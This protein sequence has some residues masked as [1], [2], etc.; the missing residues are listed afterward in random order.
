MFC[1][2]PDYNKG[3][4]FSGRSHVLGAELKRGGFKPRLGFKVGIFRTMH[5]TL[6]E[7]LDKK[8]RKKKKCNTRYRY[9]KKKLENN[10]SMIQLGYCKLDVFQLCIIMLCIIDYRLAID[11]IS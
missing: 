6:L 5:M 11:Y 7:K 2:N 8:K 10:L 3:N 1:F 4:S 9:N